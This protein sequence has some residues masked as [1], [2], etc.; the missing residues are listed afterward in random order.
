MKLDEKVNRSI[1][2][3]RF[4]NLCRKNKENLNFDLLSAPDLLDVLEHVDNVSGSPRIFLDFASQSQC[5][6]CRDIKRESDK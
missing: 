4:V 2:E 3:T 6:H 5:C 1:R